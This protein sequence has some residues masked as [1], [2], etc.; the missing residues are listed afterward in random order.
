MHL[1]PTVSPDAIKAGPTTEIE[2]GRTPSAFVANE[3]TSDTRY[4]DMFGS[5]TSAR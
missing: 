2:T 5:T 1:N 3:K 4:P